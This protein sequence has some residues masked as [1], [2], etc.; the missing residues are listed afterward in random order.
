MANSL[1][2]EQY[3]SFTLDNGLRVL[4]CHQPQTEKSNVSVA[5]RAGHFYDPDDCQGLSHLLEHMLF[6]GSRHLPKPNAINQFIEQQG[7]TIN[8]WTGTEYAN[9]HFSCS[10]E[11]LTHILPAFADMLKSPL[12]TTGSIEKEI[13]SIDAEFQ[14]KLK[15]DLRRLY[16]VHKETCNPAHPFSKFSVGNKRVFEPLGIDALHHGLR[17]YHK[18]HYCGANMT[19]CIL[20]ALPLE[21]VEVL[22][23]RALSGLPTGKPVTQDWPPL[24]QREQ[25]GVKI[26]IRP[27]QQARRMIVTFAL[28][29]LHKNVDV[30]PLDYISH[31]LGDEGQGS[32]LDYL[33]RNRL[34]TNLIAGSGIEGEDFKDFNI[35]IQLTEHGFVQQD[36]IL[37]ALFHT[38]GLVRKSLSSEWRY[39]EKARLS[40]LAQ[41]YDD[42]PKSLDLIC[43]YAEA[44]FSLPADKLIEADLGVTSFNAEVINQA[45]D[46]F[47][48]NNMRIK[49]IAPDLPVDR[50]SAY[51]K[52]E[53]SM[54]PLGSLL[55]KKLETP[56]RFDD[57]SLP[58]PNPY[59]GDNFSLTL[60]DANYLVPQQIVKSDTFSM[61]Y[62]QDHVFHSPK[63][64]I[65]LSFDSEGFSAGLREAAIKRIWLAALNDYLKSNYY[66]A[67]IAGLHYRIYGHQAGFTVHTRGFSDQQFLLAEQLVSAVFDYLP[68][69]TDFN[70]VKQHQIQLLQNALLNKPTNRLFLRLSVLIQRNT[71]APIDLLAAVENCSYDDF[72][73][74]CRKGLNNYYVE[75][76]IHGNW[77]HQEARQF[78]NKIQGLLRDAN[79]QA[80]S[81]EVVKLPINNTH[82]HKVICEHSDA[83]MVLY[84][85]APTCDL[86]DTAMCM[87]LE[88]MLAAPFFNDLRTQKQLG[89]VV[90]TGYVPHNQHPGMVFYIQSPT[91]G[92]QALLDNVTDFL[93]EQLEEIG[94][95]QGYWPDI[96]KA[97][98]KQ[99]KEHDLSLSMKSQRLWLA[100]GNQDFTF[101][102]NKRI[103]KQ[104]ESFSFDDIDSYARKLATRKVFGELVLFADGQ[105]APLNID[106]D[107][108]LLDI[109]QFKNSMEYF[110]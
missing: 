89:Y 17:H 92:A 104:I 81:R 9:Y 6:M 30:S 68:S 47:R 103:A 99:L 21:Q 76:L 38:I 15:D 93:F 96:Q 5:V 107:H 2:I 49:L 82:Y 39:N 35:S 71:H 51:Y 14:F 84:L 83:A 108:Q 50:Q 36:T 55:L 40:A 86:K 31:L 70:A 110:R 42:V 29:A 72:I 94:F 34:A 52:T 57:I 25:L 4:I 95:Y 24:Y 48:P 98:L 79:S 60:P 45:L 88:Q 64:D 43:E 62:A 106:A 37:D 53:Y 109:A 7:G 56:T 80:L 54:E 27:L 20:T 66:R 90:G 58:P 12:F 3:S 100:L 59:I 77:G 10:N 46:Y 13:E 22:V 87:V 73:S 19:L 44:L 32:L 97:M 11:H 23:N 26:N 101:D 61:W 67:E 85:Q 74:V 1:A 63:G 16:Q 102:R 105:Q 33:K 8:A 69:E 18:S 65:Y 78:T 41:Q 75:G 91:H 28:P